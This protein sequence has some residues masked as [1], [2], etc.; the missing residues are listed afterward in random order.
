MVSFFE[1]NQVCS[2]DG[3]LFFFP[4]E[5]YRAEGLETAIDFDPSVDRISRELFLQD[6][7]SFPLTKDDDE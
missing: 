6:L 2:I 3:I 5:V 7:F 4:L 1:E